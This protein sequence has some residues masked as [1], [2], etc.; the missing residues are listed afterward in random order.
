MIA[1]VLFFL[2]RMS[3]TQWL[4]AAAI[5]ILLGM[6]ARL[7]LEHNLRIKAQQRERIAQ[8]EAINVQARLDTTL[9]ITSDSIKVLGDSVDLYQKRVIQ[10]KQ[11]ASEL[12][13]KLGQFAVANYNLTLRIDALNRI[14]QSPVV[15][16]QDSLRALF[17][18]NQPPYHATADVALPKKITS[19]A[20]G[21]MNLIITQD[22]FPLSAH[23][24]CGPAGQNGVRAAYLNLI[25]PT[26]ASVRLDSLTQAIGVCSPT[27]DKLKPKNNFF[28]SVWNVTKVAVVATAAFFIG[29]GTAQ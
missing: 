14:V 24:G 29:R 4:F 23:V 2:K 8:I 9:K 18:V 6:A 3:L 25:S 22:A 16:S 19:G 11:I 7:K 28:K 12:D 13:R 27:P 17:R 5:V 15:D 1:S 20:Q 21:R 10:E 26:Y